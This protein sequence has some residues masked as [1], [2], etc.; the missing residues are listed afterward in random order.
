MSVPVQFQRK[1]MGGMVP[2][3]RKLHLRGLLLRLAWLH[4]GLRAA[5]AACCN[6]TAGRVARFSRL[7][8]CWRTTAFS[9]FLQGGWQPLRGAGLRAALQ[10]APLARAFCA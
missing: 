8:G 2:L 3:G 6:R 1:N 5:C 4:A 9:R 10:K 7:H